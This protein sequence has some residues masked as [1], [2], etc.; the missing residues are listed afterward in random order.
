MIP[1]AF[2]HAEAICKN[3]LVYRPVREQ[4][5]SF[6]P[7]LELSG[8]PCRG[9]K[10]ITYIDTNGATQ[11]LDPTKYIVDITKGR[12]RLTPAYA[13][14]FPPVRPIMNA[15]QITYDVGLLCPVSAVDIAGDTITA[16]GL[17][18]VSG[19]IAQFSVDAGTMPGNLIASSPYYYRSPSGD[20][21][22]LSLTSGGAAIDLTAGYVAPVFVGILHPTIRMALRKIL[23][24]WWAHPGDMSVAQL[25]D[26]PVHGV[27]SLLTPFLPRAF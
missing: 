2:Q 5:D 4:F 11:T 13:M 8:Y 20:T 14:Y 27:E 25:K 16:P 23:N 6:L 1:A 10:S 3:T 7:I 24:D 15:V 17:N 22:Q 12:A 19:A 18:P 9:V 21:F 26:I